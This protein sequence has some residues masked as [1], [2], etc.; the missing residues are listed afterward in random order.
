M[1]LSLTSIGLLARPFDLG[2]LSHTKITVSFY[3]W[4]KRTWKHKRLSEEETKPIICNGKR[5]DVSPNLHK[6]LLQLR[7]TYPGRYWIDAVCINQEDEDEVGKQVQMM[8]TIYQS[9]ELVRVWL[10]TGQSVFNHVLF[11]VLWALWKQRKGLCTPRDKALLT[12][13]MFLLTRKWFQRLWT[14]Q[15]ARLAK[16]LVF[17]LG[18]N[19]YSPAQVLEA[20][21]YVNEPQTREVGVDRLL[22]TALFEGIFPKSRATIHILSPEADFSGGQKWSLYEWLVMAVGRP[23]TDVKDIVFA[24]LGLISEECVKIN[25]SLIMVEGTASQDGK[26]VPSLTARKLWSELRADHKECSNTDDV[27]LN[28]A[29]CLLSQ[30]RPMDLFTVCALYNGYQEDFYD[31]VDRLPMPS[32]IPYPRWDDYV[33]IDPFICQEA[34][35]TACADPACNPK[36]SADGKTLYIDAHSIDTIEIVYPSWVP[37][38]LDS[39]L[40][41]WWDYVAKHLG[42]SLPSIYA[43]TGQCV[44]RAFANAMTAGSWDDPEKPIEEVLIQWLA[45]IFQESISELEGEQASHMIARKVMLQQYADL[46]QRFGDFVWPDLAQPLNAYDQPEVRH[47]VTLLMRVS[48]FHRRIFVTRSGY[49]GLGPSHLQQGDH[50]ML[51]QGGTVPYVFVSYLDY[52]ERHHGDVS[53]GKRPSKRSSLH[54]TSGDLDQWIFLGEA[55]VEGIMKGELE[56]KAVFKQIAVV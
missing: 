21:N 29:A 13:A 8:G 18:E 37:D 46:R 34:C 32:W 53:E 51:V 43:Q 26:Q 40:N 3:H 17:L 41:P 54:A 6:A 11:E 10:G 4:A 56:K 31:H 23:P 44:L 39:L 33:R 35:F 55:Y 19:E 47:F 30:A 2:H 12:D 22:S 25:Q 20:L 48:H 27:F 5:L 24:G 42:S 36:I 9:A 16:K 28:L 15:E 50:V 7:R 38:N 45:Q 52:V 14:L 49:V 1:F